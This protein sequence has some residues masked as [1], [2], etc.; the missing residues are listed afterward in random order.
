MLDDLTSYLHSLQMPSR[1]LLGQSRRRTVEICGFVAT[2]KSTVMTARDMMALGDQ[3]F[4]YFLRF[5]LS[6]DPIESLFSRIRQMGGF[7][8]NPDVVQFRGALWKLLCKQSVSASRSANMIS[9]S[10][11]SAM[12]EF[13]WSRRTVQF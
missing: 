6:Q 11:S 9:C 1:Q 13:T 2:A 10:S 8:N 4:N 3:P 12:F 5:R 7:N